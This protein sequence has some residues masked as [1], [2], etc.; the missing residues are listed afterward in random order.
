[1]L[2]SSET[3]TNAMS[4]VSTGTPFIIVFILIL[5][6]GILV[7]GFNRA[8]PFG[9]LGILAWLQS[10]V[11]MSP[12]LIFFGLV[13]A[14]IYLNIIGILLLLVVSVAVYIYL[15]KQLRNLG[16]DV[17]LKEKAAQRLKALSQ[18]E[19][20]SSDAIPG[21]TPEKYGDYS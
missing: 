10:L 11:L 7:W 4:A 2:N 12:W 9:K 8:K 15:G 17:M 1:M 6:V 5:A 20:P 18:L 16:Q 21:S 19:S 3:A 14:G 13:A